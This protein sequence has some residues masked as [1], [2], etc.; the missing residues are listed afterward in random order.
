[1][2]QRNFQAI[3]KSVSIVAEIELS[4]SELFGMTLNRFELK[5]L[6][7][8]E[9]NLLP[10]LKEISNIGD[11]EFSLDEVVGMNAVIETSSNFRINSSDMI[12][13]ARSMDRRDI[14]R[15]IESEYPAPKF[16][17]R[18]FFRKNNINHEAFLLL[19]SSYLVL[20]KI[21]LNEDDL[22][23]INMPEKL[24][25]MCHRKTIKLFL[26]KYTKQLD[27]RRA[28]ECPL[29]LRCSAFFEKVS[30]RGFISYS[31]SECPI[32]KVERHLESQGHFTELQ[33]GSYGVASVAHIG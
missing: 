15:L 1:M 27:C 9:K 28:H 23:K 4:P 25:K 3:L 29:K 12:T 20:S 7:L 13:I 17:E 8:N 33:I 21:K 2:N 6:G 24:I 18:K 30:D 26:H 14:S 5:K 32:Y 16:L 19:T 22:R 10:I 31:C 11:G